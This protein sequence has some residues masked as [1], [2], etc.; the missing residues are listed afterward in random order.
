MNKKKANY[1]TANCQSLSFKKFN[2][3]LRCFSN[4]SCINKCKY[5]ILLC[6]V[7]NVSKIY[8]KLPKSIFSSYYGGRKQSATCH[9]KCQENITFFLFLP[10]QL[11]FFSLFC[12]H[13]NASQL[14]IKYLEAFFISSSFHF[15]SL[16]CFPFFSIICSYCMQMNIS[17]MV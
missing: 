14:M 2:N 15:L 1:S 10:F 9:P 16:L 17:P 12:V 13:A 11:H 3:I 5:F 8:I 7:K 6:I 4:T